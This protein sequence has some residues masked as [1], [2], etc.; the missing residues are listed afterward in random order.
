[1][2]YL[3]PTIGDQKMSL[4]SWF[5][6]IPRRLVENREL[7]LRKSAAYATIAS[8]SKGNTIYVIS[9]KKMVAA[10]TK[11][12]ETELKL[13]KLCA[14]IRR[15]SSFTATATHNFSDQTIVVERKDI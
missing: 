11:D 13:K 15:Y 10:L 12:Y 5:T 9:D 6:R 2:Q 8:F 7:Q 1:M 3:P 14:R 4:L